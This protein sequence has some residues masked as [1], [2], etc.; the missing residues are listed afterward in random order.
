[1]LEGF[2]VPDFD[3]DDDPV[4]STYASVDIA[5]QSIS[6][7]DYE[8]FCEKSGIVLASSTPLRCTSNSVV[9]SAESVNGN[10]QYAIKITPHKHRV[11]EEYDK[12]NLVTDS[13]YIVKTISLSE[14][15]TKA[16]LKIEL[17]ELGDISNYTFTEDDIW[18]MIHD[19]GTAL[20]HLH[21]QGWIHLDVSPGNILI[22]ND[23]FKLADFGTLTKIGEFEEGN[24]GAGPFVSPEALAFPC[25]DFEVGPPTDIFSFGVVLFEC[26]S[27]Q[28][29]PRGGCPGYSKIR[30]GE[31]LLGQGSYPCEHSQELIDLINM[32]L[33]V[34][35]AE[36]P[37][38]EQLVQATGM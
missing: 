24:E 37:T 30:N 35:P 29:A 20:K 25:T 26:A 21:S 9:F 32:M 23:C 5:S 4:R 17:C 22:T 11:H 7:E 36:R 14:S 6:C 10:K 2:P 18:K 8:E 38:A 31:I 34:D 1:M 19:I 12:R 33:A 3:F 28:A 27:Q 15:P 16:L 13:P